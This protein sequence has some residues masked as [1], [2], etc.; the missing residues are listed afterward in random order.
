MIETRRIP[1]NPVSLVPIEKYILATMPS[2]IA[3][4]SLQMKIADF[5][6]ISDWLRALKQGGKLGDLPLFGS[7]QPIRYQL[8]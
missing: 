2:I 8:G 5:P 1:L 7:S 3:I 4:L 6:L